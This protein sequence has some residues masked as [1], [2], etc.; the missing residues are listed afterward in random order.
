MRRCVAVPPSGSRECTLGE[1]KPSRLPGPADV[2]AKSAAFAKTAAAALLAKL[3]RPRC[4]DIVP[5]FRG[6]GNLDSRG[7]QRVSEACVDGVRSRRVCGHT[8]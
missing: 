3:G 6:D 8:S 5:V 4:C 2:G 1:A 7:R